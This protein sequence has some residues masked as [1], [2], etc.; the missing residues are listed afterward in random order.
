MAVAVTILVDR[1]VRALQLRSAPRVVAVNAHRMG[2]VNGGEAVRVAK[3]RHTVRTER[4]QCVHFT[5]IDGDYADRHGSRQTRPP[6]RWWGARHD[7]RRR[8]RRRVRRQLNHAVRT[9]HKV[10]DGKGVADE[11]LYAILGARLALDV[12]GRLRTRSADGGDHDDTCSAYREC[13]IVL[14][15][16]EP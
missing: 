9:R 3:D 7:G 8:R 1:K 15:H 12:S 16:R 2:D 4:A 13:N 10:F 5:G 14:R 11:A 6:W